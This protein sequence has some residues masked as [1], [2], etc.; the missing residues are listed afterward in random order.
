MENNILQEM[1]N[2]ILNLLAQIDKIWVFLNS[3]INIDFSVWVIDFDYSF[4]FSPLQL[5]GSSILVW[6]GLLLAKSL[7]PMA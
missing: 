5:I 2:I 6:L 1:L 7:I 3:D 4:G